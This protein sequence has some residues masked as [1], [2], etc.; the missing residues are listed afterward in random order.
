[1]LA[2]AG[3]AVHHLLDR[4]HGHRLIF[5]AATAGSVGGVLGCPRGDGQKAQSV[6]IKRKYAFGRRLGAYGGQALFQQGDH[7][8]VDGF[9]I[10]ADV[11]PRALQVAAAGGR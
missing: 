10:D 11:A 7:P 3:G 8:R 5:L 4:V 9:A 2:L 1:M 6:Q